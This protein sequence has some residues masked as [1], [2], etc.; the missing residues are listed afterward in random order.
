M[1]LG[2]RRKNRFKK[3]DCYVGEF[4]DIQRNFWLYELSDFGKLTK[5][6]KISCIF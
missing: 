3:G 6:K 2:Q 4:E 5:E 1:V